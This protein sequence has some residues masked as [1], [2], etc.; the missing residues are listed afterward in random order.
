VTS[1]KA[2]IKLRRILS[3][4][5]TDE[6]GENTN[7]AYLGILAPAW[8]IGVEKNHSHRG[9]PKKSVQDRRGRL[10]L[11]TRTS[12]PRPGLRTLFLMK[13]PAFFALR[14]QCGRDVR[15]PG[16]QLTDLL[17]DETHH[18]LLTAYLA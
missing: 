6:T 13:E 15:V 7:I 12:R 1:K 11:G 3:L 10:M 8:T 14:A 4:A 16:N 17:G 18:S 2:T 5:N 9:L